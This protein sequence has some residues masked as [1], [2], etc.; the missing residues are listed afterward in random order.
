MAT[1]RL[2][3]RKTREILRLKWVLK[4]SHREIT[5]ALGV[6]LSTISETASRAELVGLDWAGVEALDDDQLEAR[7]YPSSSSEAPRPLP[8]PAALDLEL[9]RVGVTLRLLHHEYLEANPGGYGYTQ[10]CEVYR[11]WR[12]QRKL[13]MRQ[14][15]KAGDKLFV[16]YSGKRPSIVD[17]TSGERV[18][19]ELFVAV[20]GASNYT[21]AEATRTQ[22]VPDWL[23]SHARTFEFLDGVTAA[24]V[25]DQLKS[26]VT[27]ADRYEPGLQRSYEEMG[28]HYGT[29][30]IPARPAHPKDKAKVEVGVQIAQRWILARLRNQIFFSLDELNARIRELLTDLNTRVMRR[31]G[32]S[33]RELFERLDRPALRALPSTRFEWSE[34]KLCRA[35]LDYHVEFDHHFY[36]VPYQLA[37]EQVWV[38]ATATMIEAFHKIT[39]VGLHVRSYQ[40]GAVTTDPAHRSVLHQKHAEWTPDR[41]VRWAGQLGVHAATLVERLLVEHKHPEHGYRSCIG[42]VRLEKKYGGERLD[43]A[44]ARVLAVGG[45][46]YTHVEAILRHGLD[47]VPTPGATTDDA[48]PIGDHE[49]VRGSDY[50]H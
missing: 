40:H 25:P 42:L 16:D 34:W 48:A 22:Q 36:S 15:H 21:Y 30:I 10:F 28:R 3:M 7:L 5:R 31:Y 2:S 26:G 43:A 50:Y 17:A 4:R 39:R 38:R 6:G 11:L 41:L 35:Q 9:R 8:D 23:G 12:K 1:E 18:E 33:R 49:N 20:L 45:R 24:V 27:R 29:A 32:V 13:S 44:C 14:E 19:V 46:S 37:E 47:R